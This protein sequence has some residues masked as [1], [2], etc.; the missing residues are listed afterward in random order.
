MCLI[1]MK[2][3]QKTADL[4]EKSKDKTAGIVSPFQTNESN[5][6]LGLMMKDTLGF[7]PPITGDEINY[8][9]GFRIRLTVHLI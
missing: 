3:I 5:Y 1:G 6:L 8:P 7:L 4:I 9:T 2:K